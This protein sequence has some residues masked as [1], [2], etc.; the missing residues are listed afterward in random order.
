MIMTHLSFKGT[1]VAVSSI[2]NIHSKVNSC[3]LYQ[4]QPPPASSQTAR[5]NYSTPSY[6][7][8]PHLS[9]RLSSS[10]LSS[11]VSS[12]VSVANGACRTAPAFLNVRCETLS[13]AYYYSATKAKKLRRS[14][15]KQISI[16]SRLKTVAL[17]PLLSIH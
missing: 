9:D 4:A 13:R 10:S 1:G 2:I 8:I 14:Q 17:R 11:S 6:L 5:V 3:D 7:Q 12:P 15:N 16:L